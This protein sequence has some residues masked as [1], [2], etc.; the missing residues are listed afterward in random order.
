[1]KP[2]LSDFA[3]DKRIARRLWHAELGEMQMAIG[4]IL[5]VTINASRR[6]AMDVPL[7]KCTLMWGRLSAI[8]N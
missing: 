5:Y 4:G 7:S 2:W 8:A 3:K 6:S 1:M